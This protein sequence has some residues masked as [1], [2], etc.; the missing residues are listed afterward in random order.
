MK[1]AGVVTPGP[2]RALESSGP[3]DSYD[4]KKYFT[5]NMTR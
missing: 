3:Q 5:L 2:P 1:K 4:P